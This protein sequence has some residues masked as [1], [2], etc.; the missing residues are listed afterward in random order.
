MLISFALEIGFLQI[1]SLKRS[2]KIKYWQNF[3]FDGFINNVFLNKLEF[4]TNAYYINA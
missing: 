4:F 3:I 1:M 2:N